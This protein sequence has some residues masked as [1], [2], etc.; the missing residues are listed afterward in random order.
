MARFYAFLYIFQG[1]LLLKIRGVACIFRGVRTVE[2]VHG[3]PKARGAEG[4]GGLPKKFL[5]FIGLEN[6]LSRV[7]QRTVS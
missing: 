7:F 6:A 3:P 1:N 4:S 2:N 5:L